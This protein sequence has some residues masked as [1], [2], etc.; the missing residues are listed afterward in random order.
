MNGLGENHSGPLVLVEGS[1]FKTRR[2]R[3][4]EETEHSDGGGEYKEQHTVLLRGSVVSVHKRPS[5]PAAAG[6]NTCSLPSSTL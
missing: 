3:K 6:V 1:A 2:E 5:A 4:E